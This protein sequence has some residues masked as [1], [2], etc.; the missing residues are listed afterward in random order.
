VLI[1][2]RRETSRPSTATGVF[3]ACHGRRPTLA[4]SA[5]LIASAVLT[6]ALAARAQ[7]SFYDTTRILDL[8]NK[9]ETLQARLACSSQKL[10]SDTSVIRLRDGKGVIST[11]AGR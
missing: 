8:C 2:V 11:H 7:R 1:A 5:V 3:D 4:A 6:L 9:S 10:S